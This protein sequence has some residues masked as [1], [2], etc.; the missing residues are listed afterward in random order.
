MAGAVF[1]LFW[2]RHG[3][4]CCCSSCR[5]SRKNRLRPLR[6]FIHIRALDPAAE[7]ALGLG[8][9]Q[10]TRFREL[11]SSFD[12]SDLVIHVVSAGA[13]PFGVAG[14]TRLVARTG[15]YRYVRIAIDP[16]LPGDQRAAVLGHELQHA[17]ELAHGGATTSAAVL[18]MYLRIGFRVSGGL[19]AF[20]TRE[21]INAGRAVWRELLQRAGG[22]VPPS[23]RR[24]CQ[25]R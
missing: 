15:G 18:E 8:L 14:T 17:A 1:F 12:G 20:D 24:S 13:L 9:A 21:A 7:E 16:G 6:R 22:R 23:S 25:R 3:P 10:S 2:R 4:S 5:S 19:N 11:V